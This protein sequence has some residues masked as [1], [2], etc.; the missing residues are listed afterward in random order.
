MFSVNMELSRSTWML[1]QRAAFPPIP[2]AAVRT[3]QDPRLHRQLGNRSRR[4]ISTTTSPKQASAATAEKEEQ[5]MEESLQSQDSVMQSSPDATND[6]QL[7]SPSNTEN[8]RSPTKTASERINLQSLDEYMKDFGRAS[9]PNGRTSPPQG[10]EALPRGG[11][12]NLRRSERSQ[13]QQ[14]STQAMNFGNRMYIPSAP[15]QVKPAAE[16]TGYRNPFDPLS[17]QPSL[18]QLTHVPADLSPPPFRLGPSLGRTIVTQ[19]ASQNLPYAFRQLEINCGRNKVKADMMK[20]RFHERPGLKRK[21]L[22]SERWRKRFKADFQ[23]VCR[24]VE[25]LRRKGW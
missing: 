13:S 18:P 9:S 5:T 8:A 19:M 22:A 6:S 16:G 1:L 17:S 2:R 25:E 20:Q 7:P 4:V 11:G 14:R 24:R 15:G 3:L 10:D 21:R 12:N 23:A